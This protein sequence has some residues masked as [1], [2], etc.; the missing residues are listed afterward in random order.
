MAGEIFYKA[1]VGLRRGFRIAPDEKFIVVED[2]VTRGSRVQETIDIVYARSGF[3]S[4]VC[5]IVDH[6]GESKPDFG[7]P[8]V[9]LIEMNLETFPA[10]TLPLEP[11]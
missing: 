5:V 6:T 11:R 7:F 4:A 2:V 9:R 1:N 10:E 8:F 3:A